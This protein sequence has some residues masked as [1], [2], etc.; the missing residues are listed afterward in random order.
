MKPL[1]PTDSFRRARPALFAASLALM[2]GLSACGGS[3]HDGD[4]DNPPAANVEET[5]TTPTPTAPSSNIKVDGQ[6]QTVQPANGG[7]RIALAP[8]QWAYG[9]LPSGLSIRTVD[10]LTLIEAAPGA[11]SGFPVSDSTVVSLVSGTI[12]DLSGNGQYAIGRWTDGSD[13]GGGAYNVN[14]GRGWTAGTPATVSLAVGQ[15]MTC[16][17]GA[18]TRPTASNGNVAP[19]TIEAASATF[20]GAQ[21][22]P[23]GSLTLQYSIGQ[24][25]HQT[26]TTSS[27]TLGGYSSNAS[28]QY[29]LMGTV[30]GTDAAHPWYLV[31]YSFNTPTSGQV[32]G[33]A[34]LGC[35][36]HA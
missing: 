13:S 12:T 26:L 35:E 17:L 15:V 21:P 22:T 9:S 31:V 32:S 7:V 1:Q 6:S 23:T 10:P 20:T 11:Y 33:V 28:Q 2:L 8:T 16:V 34:A 27:A 36:L 18:A 3:D 30:A 4:A 29:A 25:E 5:P 14:Q 19:G 24:D